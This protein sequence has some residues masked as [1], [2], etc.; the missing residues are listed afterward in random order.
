[1]ALQGTIDQFAPVDVLP[2]LARTQQTGALV[3]RGDDIGVIYCSQG[4][5]TFAAARPS[6]G[7]GEVLVGRGFVGTDEWRR[8]VD[9]C[10]TGQTI[11]ALLFDGAGID[12]AEL[13]RALREH[14]EE[15]TFLISQWTE[16]DF[17]FLA[18]EEHL[19]GRTC[20]VSVPNLI[21]AVD[22]RQAEWAV[23]SSIVPSTHVAVVPVPFLP[24]DQDSVTLTRAEWRVLAAADGQRTIDQLARATYQSPFATCRVVHGLVVAGLVEV[25]EESAPEPEPAPVAEPVAEPVEHPV[26][27]AAPPAAA[28]QAKFVSSHATVTTDEAPPAAQP[29]PEPEPVDTAAVL[30]D[31]L[32]AA[33]EDLPDVAP[34]RPRYEG[35]A[36]W[37]GL[38]LRRTLPTDDGERSHPKSEQDVVARLLAAI[39]QS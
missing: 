21:A 37:A 4:E 25:G 22:Q 30:N 28:A 17:Q 20:T 18:G 14:I 2:F 16:G 7:L 12:A 10:Q 1:V 32:V 23:I 36:P 24:E 15:A 8:I 9:Q 29:E 31:A 35:E 27:Q 34:P 13:Q 39:E 3:V 19:L 26:A 38:R 6:D 33:P 11:G 5:V